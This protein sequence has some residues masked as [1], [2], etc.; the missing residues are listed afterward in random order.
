MII[1]ETINNYEIIY[2]N[3]D[4][5]QKPVITEKQIFDNFYNNKN[6]PFNYIA[7]PWATYIDNIWIHK[8]DDM[9]FH[10]NHE[11]ENNEIID[12]NKEYFTVC[13]HISFYKHLEKINKLNIKYIFSPHCS[14]HINELSKQYNIHIIPLSLFPTHFNSSLSFIPNYQKKYLTSF[15]GQIHHKGLISNIREKMY[16]SFVNK[17]DCFIKSN[18]KW[19]FQEYVYGKNN[20]HL[21]NNHKQDEFYINLLANSKFSLCPSGTGP[22][23]IR[24]WESLSFGSIP[25]IL[26][27]SLM[28]PIIPDIDYN[29]YFIFWNECDID[30]LY[31]HLKTFNDETIELMS[32]RCIQLFNEYFSNVSMH[33][34]ITFYFENKK[35]ILV[36]GGSG[37]VGSAI[38]EISHSYMNKYNFIFVNSQMCNLLDYNMTLEFFKKYE[39]DFVIHLAANVGGLYKNMEQP[40]L[41]LQD[42]LQININVL[43]ACHSIKV[44]KLIA[45]LS[46]CIFPDIINYPISEKDLH[47]GPPHFSNAG[48]AYSKRILQTQCEAYNKQYNDNFLCIIP[49]NIYGPHDNFNLQDSHVIPGLIHKCYL[50]KQNNTKFII[51]G[52]G[53]PQRQFIFSTDLANGIM[54]VLENY[55]QAD[56]IIISPNIEDEVSIEYIARKIAKEFDYDNIEF[57]LSKSDGQFKKTVSNE[58]FK[59]HFPEFEFTNIDVG[60]TNTINWFKNNYT[61]IRK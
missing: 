30:K 10:I 25:I 11:I 9:V 24:L 17:P 54:H 1:K 45:C 33:K 16:H 23:S 21:I 26:A 38:K 31:D 46:T 59:N 61:H 47:S 22:N 34:P 14:N 18:E 12:K 7:F 41:L 57:D 20:I 35:T 37:L 5:W 43:K 58:K 6:I 4:C 15:I 2:I 52:S 50:A 28:L 44:K 19:F 60:I 48:Y 55:N 56:S 29:D 13:Q 39:P 53:K 27:D 36:T 42:N 3:N 40:V 8:H 32:S 49:T 51:S